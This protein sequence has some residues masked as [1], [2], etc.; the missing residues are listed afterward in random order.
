MQLEA[1]KKSLDLG[2]IQM[3]VDTEASGSGENREK[4]A[5]QLNDLSASTLAPHHPKSSSEQ[6]QGALLK[7]GLLM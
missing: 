7:T 6:S 1:S 4:K 2:V 3:K 5:I